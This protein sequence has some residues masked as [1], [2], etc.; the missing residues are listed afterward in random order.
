MVLERTR[1]EAYISTPKLT[2]VA[3]EEGSLAFTFYNRT[4]LPDDF[5]FSISGLP[6]N[7]CTFSKVSSNLM[8]N[9]KEE[10]TL[11][12]NLGAKVRPDTY[13]GA[14]VLT[15]RNQPAVRVELALTVEVLAPLV[16]ADRLQPHRAKAYKAK[17]ELI[18]R[19]RSMSECF[20]T[21]EMGSSNPFCEAKFNPPNVRVSPGQA[22]VVKTEV[23]LSGKVPRDQKEQIQT[24][25]IE[26]EPK[27]L[28]NGELTS[29]ATQTVE[30]E[31]L[32]NS[33][34]SFFS[35]NAKL[36]INLT[37][38]LVLV[39]LWLILF[40]LL[41]DGLAAI[42]TDKI[43]VPN[44]LPA[45]ELYIEQKPVTDGLQN[46][47]PLAAFLKTEVKFDESTQKTSLFVKFLFFGDPIPGKLEVDQ[48][49]GR[50]VFNPD[51]PGQV[52]SFPL[53]LLPPNKVLRNISDKLRFVLRQQN[54]RLDK[55]RIEG[56]TLYITTRQCTPGEPACT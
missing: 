40:P 43:T 33:P 15:A 44:P 19:N 11:T 10:I 52:D 22:V 17:Y 32:Y 23:S 4:P 34:L 20:V 50:L 6:A 9:W 48:T 55:T 8:P 18:L 31:Y 1:L 37:V 45:R 28:V 24:F 35:R 7:W 56:T 26:L 36:L 12:I 42:M 53:I 54:L 25:E 29:T 27:W 2:L 5:D 39:I 3:G 14:I 41:Q 21:M 13:H 51:K 30:G 16:L 47:N 49:S 46:N 38:L